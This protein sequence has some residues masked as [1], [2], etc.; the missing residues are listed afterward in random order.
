MLQDVE[1]QRLPDEL[2]EDLRVLY[3]NV[4]R[5]TRIAQGLLSFARLS[6]A[7]LRPINVNAMI[8]ET[9]LLVGKHLA[10]EGVQV[11]V[12]LDRTLSPIW[13]D[14]TALQQVMT[15]LLF[16]AR[17]AMS[18]G[19]HVHIETAPEPNRVGWLRVTI[20][21]TGEGMRPETLKK[22]WEP[23]YTTKTGGTG[24][25]LSVSH[26]IIR[27]H[28]GDVEVQSEPGRGTTFIIRFPSLSSSVSADLFG[29]SPEQQPPSAP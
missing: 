17:D 6:P 21:D 9:L 27:E 2:V 10:Q 20:T 28:G 15:N 12:T 13:G 7:E 19:G 29:D 5:V 18:F 1:S 14:G 22:I 24:L 16:N 26:K 4:Q 25:G 11:S 23:F 8:E 3:R